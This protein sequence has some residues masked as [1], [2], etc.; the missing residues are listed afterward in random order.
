[1]ARIF[2]LLFLLLS[3]LFF[4]C[5]PASS[6]E[7]PVDADL[8]VRLQR[9]R[10]L[11]GAEPKKSLDS[12]EAS[13]AISRR[14]VDSLAVIRMLAEHAFTRGNLRRADSLYALANH[15][16]VRN[17]LRG[18]EFLM[19]RIGMCRVYQF[20]KQTDYAFQVMDSLLPVAQARK[21][22][23][24][25]WHV[26]QNF[27]QYHIS[28]TYTMTEAEKLQASAAQTRSW[29]DRALDIATGMRDSVLMSN[30]YYLYSSYFIF[31]RKCDSV[32]WA[33][34]NML[35]VV[36][37]KLAESKQGRIILNE[38]NCD[39]YLES[40]KAK[41]P[42]PDPQ[43]TLNAYRQAARIFKKFDTRAILSHTYRNLGAYHYIHQ[44]LDSA[45]FYLEKAKKL[46]LDNDLIFYASGFA[47]TLAAVAEGAEDYEKAFTYFHEHSQ[48][49]ERYSSQNHAEQIRRLEAEYEAT[50]LD[51][52]LTRSRWLNGGLLAGLIV[53]LLIVFLFYRSWQF[54][55]RSANE[56]A[57]VNQ[58]LSELNH[59][60]DR[61]FSI[62]SHDLK[63]PLSA[64]RNISQSLSRQWD[65]LEREQVEPFLQ[66][67]V[68]ASQNTFDLLQN[69][70]QWAISQ[71][72]E[73]SFHPQE[74]DLQVL[75]FRNVALLTANADQKQIQ[76]VQNIPDDSLV[77]ADRRMLE[78]VVQN[79]LSNAIKF[80]SAGG[81]IELSAEIHPDTI[82]FLLADNGIGLSEAQQQKLFR[83]DE[84]PTL[85]GDHPEKGTGLG[86]I[87]CKELIQRNN[88]SISVE[89]ELGKGSRF[90]VI[91]PRKLD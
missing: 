81:Q 23:I 32:K 73:I 87:L 44:E 9:A 5:Q 34:E 1:M 58:R 83:L 78:T 35:S 18:H 4:A 11:I 53:L 42:N 90:R 82:H 80:T 60:K 17:Q 51:L 50:E 77:M 71:T 74:I 64:L 59:T 20:V 13:L 45:Y 70:L 37:G 68:N 47:Q 10:L 41:E 75:A 38:L 52:S 19:T 25:L 48:L 65:L 28:R 67:M 36:S 88:G 76:I 89:S 43:A 6:N 69:L 86:L 27:V 33:H 91:L 2:C 56:L 7:P 40:I 14:P 29:I 84:D 54:R 46:A 30:S 21:D 72:G 85:I 22:S 55:K 15:L 3:L 26:A 16:A 57:V 66:S 79:L 62:I 39:A 49:E 31:Q 12:L 61:L 63:A 24:L 8:T